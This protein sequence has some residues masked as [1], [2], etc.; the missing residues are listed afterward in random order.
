VLEIDS[1][2]GS[3]HRIDPPV[4][5][6]IELPQALSCPFAFERIDEAVSV[7]IHP[8]GIAVQTFKNSAPSPLEGHEL[9]VRF[10][11]H[12]RG[13]ALLAMP[14]EQFLPDAAAVDRQ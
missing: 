5:V 10:L 2:Q 14:F 9:L 13:G 12:R 3:L 6:P 4:T 1:S 8:A 7:W 11:D